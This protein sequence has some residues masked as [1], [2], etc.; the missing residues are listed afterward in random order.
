VIRLS[1]E[2]TIKLSEGLYDKAL[3]F[4]HVLNYL[5]EN[6]EREVTLEEIVKT[7]LHYYL[8]RFYDN[9]INE[10]KNEKVIALGN[11]DLPLRFNL[12]PF[13]EEKNM[14]YTHIAKQLG[15]SLGTLKG[16]INNKHMPS[17]DIFIRLWVLIGCPPLHEI[18]YREKENDQHD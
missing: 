17:V 1:K 7:S 4:V 8:C 5:N 14:Q 16:I 12:E 11:P 3:S 15:V 18:L 13:I 10:H 9:L 2:L 6:V